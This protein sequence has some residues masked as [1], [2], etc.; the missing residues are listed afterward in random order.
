M[1][2]PYNPELVVTSASPASPSK[3]QQRYPEIQQLLRK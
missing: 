2:L 3:E 1:I